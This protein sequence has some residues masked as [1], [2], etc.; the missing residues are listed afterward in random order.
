MDHDSISAP[1]RLVSHFLCHIRPRVVE[2]ANVELSIKALHLARFE[3][4][5]L[6]SDQ[7]ET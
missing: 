2:D 6:G 5:A 7:L 3:A 1:R 4:S